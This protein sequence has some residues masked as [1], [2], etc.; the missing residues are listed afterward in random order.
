MSCTRK[1]FLCIWYQMAVPFV[2]CASQNSRC[3]CGSTA[4]ATAKLTVE[5]HLEISIYYICRFVTQDTE[6]TCLVFIHTFFLPHKKG[7]HP[8]FTHVKD[9]LISLGGSLTGG[10]VGSTRP[11]QLCC[12][13]D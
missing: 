6:C 1:K 7:C 9:I 13:Q 2:L 4:P 5:G 12:F 3:R 10:G 11:H 8:P